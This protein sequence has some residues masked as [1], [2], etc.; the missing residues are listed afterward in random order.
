[1][2]KYEVG[3]LI[4]CKWWD[5]LW[6]VIGISETCNKRRQGIVIRRYS[7]GSTYRNSAYSKDFTLVSRPISCKQQNNIL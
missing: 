4:M 2:N 1:M 6:L 3:D 5:T 7:R